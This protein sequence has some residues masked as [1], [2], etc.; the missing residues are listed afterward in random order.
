MKDVEVEVHITKSNTGN[1]KA[2]KEH[3]SKD[4]EVRPDEIGSVLQNKEVESDTTTLARHILVGHKPS[5]RDVIEK[6]SLAL[7]GSLA[8]VA[9]GPDVFVDETRRTL[10]DNVIKAKGMVDYYE[11][12]FT[13]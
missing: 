6:E 5:L 4:L 9:C 2:A 13:W 7:V 1:V 12:A 11:E 10:A 8:V 3:I